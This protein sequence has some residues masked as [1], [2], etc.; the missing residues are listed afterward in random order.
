MDPG[1]PLSTR[2]DASTSRA[3]EFNTNFTN[4]HHYRDF[5]RRWIRTICGALQADPRTK[6]ALHT[7]CFP[8]FAAFDG[9]AQDIPRQSELS[10]RLSMDTMDSAE[11]FKTILEEVVSVI[12]KDTATEFV[13]R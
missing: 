4:K 11:G 7:V 10:G 9:H 8:I 3:P 1:G 12:A 6:A 5:L 2:N 13:L